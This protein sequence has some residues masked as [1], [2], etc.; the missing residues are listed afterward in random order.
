VLRYHPQT[1]SVK[2]A[3]QDLRY[4][5]TR[6]LLKE[7]NE[8]NLSDFNIYEQEYFTDADITEDNWNLDDNQGFTFSKID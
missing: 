3:A 7:G 6:T 5:N 4:E 2:Q 1:D 8:Y